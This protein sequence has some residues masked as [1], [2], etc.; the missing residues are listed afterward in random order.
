MLELSDIQSGVLRPRPT[1]YAATYILLRIDKPDAGRTLMGR[2]S[3]VVASAANLNSPAGES[4]I[5]A[6]LTFP[7]LVA[8]GLPQRSLDSFAWEFR[9]G[10]V[11]RATVLGDTGDSSPERWESPLGSD[12]VHVIVTALAPD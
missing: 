1:P 2:L 11:A 10:M 12:D 8:L 9:Q 7:G 4:W 3:K 6:S 5:S